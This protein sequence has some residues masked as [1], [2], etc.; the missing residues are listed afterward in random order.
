[1]ESK[2]VGWHTVS[3]SATLSHFSVAEDTGLSNE[4]VLERQSQYGRNILAKKR[5][6]GAL[7][8][9]LKQF[10]S[11]LVLIL[12]GAGIITL[13]LDHT[14]DAIIIFIALTINVVIGFFQEQRASQA[15]EKLNSTQEQYA[16]VIRNG[17]K[18]ILSSLELVPG[19]IVVLEAGMYVPAD[20]RLVTDKGLSVNEAA[21]TGEWIAV[22]KDSTKERKDTTPLAERENMVWMGTLVANG[23]G[24]GVVVETGMRTQVGAIANQLTLVEER[25]T[26]LQQNIRRIA[27]FLL[28][29]IGGA[30]FFIFLLGIL[31]GE[32][33]SEMFLVA[34]A[35]AVASTPSGLPAA[36]TI[37]LAIGMESILKKGG[38]VR[39]LLGA[40]T[41][42]S[43][44]IILTD[45]TG[46]LTEAKMKVSGLY[47]LEGIEEKIIGPTGDNLTLLSAALLSS[48]A[49]IENKGADVEELVVQG[50]PMEKALIFAGIDDGIMQDGLLKESPR[51]DFLTFS[52]SRR[53]SASLHKNP[54]QGGNMLYVS[55]APEEILAR[56]TFVY[57]KHKIQKLTPAIRAT[58]VRTQNKMSSEGLRFVALAQKETGLTHIPDEG[59]DAKR[60]LV[61]ELVFVGLIAF[62]DPVRADVADSIKSVQG[63]G[64]RVVMVTGDNPKTAKKIALE[65]GIAKENDKVLTGNDIEALNDE[66]LYNAIVKTSVFARVL[67]E[68]KLRIARILKDHNEVVAMTGDGV[69]DAPALQSADIGIAVG[70]GTEVAKAASDIVLLNNSFTIITS[71]IA[72]G[73]RIIDNLR[74]IVSYLLSTSFSEIALI[75]GALAFGAPLPLLP[76]QILWANI[77]EEGFM[78]FAFAFEKA[79]GGV[80]T[81]SPH[82][83]SAG[84]VLS[85]DIK[86]L[87][88][89]I[90]IITGVLLIVLYAILHALNLPIEEIRTFMFVALSLDSI[91]FAFS[92]K[93]LHRPIWK[94]SFFDNWYLFFALSGSIA[95]LLGALLLPPLQTLLS[96]TPLTAIEMVALLGI[97]LLNLAS[98]EI[99][100]YF[101]FERRRER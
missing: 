72:E 35:I 25:E 97:G 67:P 8:L 13:F 49:F 1:M 18:S 40:E 33:V 78:S 92:F 32:S 74:K 76:G 43:T 30:V 51:L 58:I 28:Y 46:T 21:L 37:V 81:R 7:G 85:R 79:G 99:V 84:L 52:S 4:V 77:V 71:A 63:A 11:S 38:L 31:R 55:G 62:S 64:I 16:T 20:M 39:N 93:S 54:E 27:R 90:S 60:P 88:A 42:G 80:M 73:R 53:F 24:V 41:L 61:Q 96:L 15:F 86:K 48:D 87:I 68:Q 100:K 65:V 70:S 26:P 22:E 75:G 57:H 69:N 9:V 17:K 83:A 59:T 45:K 10:K 91:F 36:V 2:T 101:L 50:R 47:S 29:V 44:T 6:L 89:V 23:Y 34:I 3:K 98:I 19:D 56:A 82:S 95:V 14:L 94:I 12:L 5:T 66:E